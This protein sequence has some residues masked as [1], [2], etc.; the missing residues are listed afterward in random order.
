MHTRGADAVYRADG[1]DDLAL[2]RARLVDLLLELGCGDAIG[3]IE[4]LVADGATGRQA[5][6]GKRQPRIGHLRGRHQNLAAVACDAIGDVPAPELL[7][8]LR[9][10]AQVK[11]AV[12]ELHLLGAA[13]QYHQR[14]HAEHP[15]RNGAHRGEPGG[16]Q[17]SQPFHQGLHC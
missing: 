7:D 13:P 4:D 14:Q 9:C 15:K 2:E 17:S 3:T 11:I 16:P 12:E 1:A 6:A 5:L 10:I 8:D